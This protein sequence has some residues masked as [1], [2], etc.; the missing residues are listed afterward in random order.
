MPIKNFHSGLFAALNV[1]TL[2]SGDSIPADNHRGSSREA[3]S[4]DFP[5]VTHLAS[6]DFQ[7]NNDHD[8]EQRSPTYIPASPSTKIQ[9]LLKGP[10][11]LELV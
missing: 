11:R 2:H 4:L 5:V 7:G 1:A 6:V 3:A 9:D 8:Q 10:D